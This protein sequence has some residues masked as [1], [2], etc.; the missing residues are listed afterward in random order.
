VLASGDA[1]IH[2]SAAETFG[3]AASEALAS[4]LP[5]ILPDEGAVADIARRP[6]AELYA[7]GSAH[8]AAAAIERLLDRDQ[9]TLR[10]AAHA[11]AARARTLDDH[12]VDLFD[13]YERAAL[14][15]R[16]AA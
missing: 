9:E 10:A 14:P 15:G 7:A 4:G 6:F 16:R 3:L 5:L 1:L 8:A 11:A 12:F 2:G 13:A